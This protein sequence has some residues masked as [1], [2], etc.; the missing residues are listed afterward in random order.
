MLELGLVPKQGNAG[1]RFFPHSGYLGVSP[2]I[3]A[4]TAVAKLPQ[5]CQHL[6]VKAVC[7]VVRCYET[8]TGGPFGQ[9]TENVLW[10]KTKRLWEPPGADEFA[11]MGD[12]ECPFRISIPTDAITRTHS[13]QW[14]KEWKLVWRLDVVIDHK[15]IPYVGHRISKAYALNLQNHR[16]PSLPPLSPPS[17]ISAPGAQIHLNAPTEQGYR[18]PGEADGISGSLIELNPRE[19][20]E[21]LSVESESTSP[22]RAPAFWRRSVSPRPPYQRLT[23]DPPSPEV[24]PS[25]RV[26][27]TKVIETTCEETTPGSAGTYWCSTQ[28][29]IPNRG[30]KWDSGET[31]RS[32][33]VSVHFDLRVKVT[34]RSSK[35]SSPKEFTCP[36]VPVI[37]VATSAAERSEAQAFAALT[38]PSKA[39]SVK[40]K[41]RSSRRGLY[42]H[43]GT[44][45]ISDPI[46]N[47]VHTTQRRRRTK[48]QTSSPVLQSVPSIASDIKPILLSADHPAQSHNISFVFPTPL[49]HSSPQVREDI[50]RSDSRLPSIQSLLSPQ[51]RPPS[52]PS[53]TASQSQAQIDY[54]SISILRQFQ[55]TG[56]RISTSTSEEEEMQP[57]RSRQKVRDDG[58]GGL[59]VFERPALPSL[60]ALGLGL[61]Q[62]PEHTPGRTN[63]PRTAP[64]HSTFAMAG[65]VPPP[66][67]GS[68]P[69]SS[70]VNGRP[71]TSASR[72]AGVIVEDEAS[73]EGT[74]AFKVRNSGP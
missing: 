55:Q 24:D 71:R 72:F 54:D 42:M 39:A 35:R 58:T 7:V 74:F 13:S 2:V 27:T 59:A 37:L 12:W 29:T 32:P 44:T 47:G 5:L 14:T 51:Y 68:R 48:S 53:T 64:V 46:V 10:E 15:P 61:P 33:L 26:V 45:E 66:L 19:R 16:T 18:H 57:S 1:G 21:S 22:P 50:N 25:S 73:S 41:H 65:A 62:I 67:F 23:S 63:R 17:P 36:P 30:G 40:R 4:G 38:T 3:I 31:L 9:N 70:D 49:L 60:D 43:E 8:R 20:R 28:L 11:D 52:P 56:R 69:N 34:F 6:P